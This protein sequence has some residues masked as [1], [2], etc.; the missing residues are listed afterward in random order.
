M[1]IPSTLKRLAGRPPS[2]WPVLS[3]YV[4]TRPVGSAMTTYRPFLK[5][6]FAEELAQLPA[7]SPEHESL[8]VD[9]ARV[10]HYLD[11]DLREDTQA[12]AVFASYAGGDLFDAVQLPVEFP[13]QEVVAGPMPILFPLLRVADR[14]W[15]AAVAVTDGQTTRLFVM[16]MGAVE[17]RRELRAPALARPES[18][19]HEPAG[20]PADAARAVEELARDSGASWI[21]L[22]GEASAAAEMRRSLAGEFSAR[23]L[24]VAEW[25]PRAPEAELAADV[26]RR[27]AAREEAAR[28]EEALRLVTA[29]PNSTAVL[30]VAPTIAA[31]GEDRVG[32]IVI[33]ESFPEDIPA[34]T[35]R[36]CRA[37]GAGAPPAVCPTCGR[38]A[39]AVVPLREEL[40]SRAQA[41]GAAVRFVTRDAVAAFEEG[42]GV[43]AFLR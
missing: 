26:T 11:Y 35:C 18:S 34:W 4:N 20:H 17:T 14:D 25:D 21:V 39:L 19:G 5:Q 40:G 37:F 7:R 42:G 27:V 22:G 23:V 36:S 8:S 1:R 12:A 16:A 28:T 30:G 10:R 24:D 9:F 41:R 32:T 2:P 29:A 15:R 33:A 3:V 31:L 43:G 13:E 38:E 6:R